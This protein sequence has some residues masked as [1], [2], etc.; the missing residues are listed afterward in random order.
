MGNLLLSIHHV[1]FSEKS[2]PMAL[3]DGFSST[4]AK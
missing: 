3:V 1:T 4:Y 2:T